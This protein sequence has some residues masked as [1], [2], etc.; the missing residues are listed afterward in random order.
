M[1]LIFKRWGLFDAYHAWDNN[2]PELIY[3]EKETLEK[4]DRQFIDNK[5][6]SHENVWEYEYKIISWINRFM[7]FL[8]CIISSITTGYNIKI[9]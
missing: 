8:F 7:I 6:I 3:S 1:V 2:F 4:V 9:Y 5:I